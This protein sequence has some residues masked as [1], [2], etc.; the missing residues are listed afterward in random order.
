MWNLVK[1]VNSPIVKA[2]VSSPEVQTL[3]SKPIPDLH[4]GDLNSALSALG[5]EISV[6]DLVFDKYKAMLE[7]GT[8]DTLADSL[9]TTENLRTFVSLFAQPD[10]QAN[11]KSFVDECCYFLAHANNEQLDYVLQQPGVEDNLF[12]RL[13][14]HTTIF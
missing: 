7:N 8:A 5:L 12:P 11:A 6:P 3:L 2:L 1:I 14:L 10:S 9:G 13:T 4:A